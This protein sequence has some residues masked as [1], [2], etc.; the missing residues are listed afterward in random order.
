MH[1]IPIP[2]NQVLE[3]E[4]NTI[5]KK[6]ET[7]IDDYTNKL[8]SLEE[9]LS[10]WE[11]K[12]SSIE[13]DARKTAEEWEAKNGPMERPMTKAEIEGTKSWEIIYG[14]KWDSG[15]TRMTDSASEFW[16]DHRG[17][18]K[19]SVSSKADRILAERFPE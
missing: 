4:K 13:D 11:T 9:K 6:Y 8:S 7:K 16:F 18:G 15:T 10:E 1:F 5:A 19:S 2:K 14:R 3:R 17:M 12:A